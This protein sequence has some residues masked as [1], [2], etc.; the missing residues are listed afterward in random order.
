MSHTLFASRDASPANK[1]RVGGEKQMGL[2]TLPK[3]ESDNLN[4]YENNRLLV[5]TSYLFFIRRLFM[6]NLRQMTPQAIP[7]FHLRP[8][9]LRQREELRSRHLIF[10]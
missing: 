1:L 4:I 2:E 3:G 7:L 8:R 6:I 10:S 9:L 5:Q